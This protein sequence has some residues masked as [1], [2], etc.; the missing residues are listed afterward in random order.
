MIPNEN[1]EVDLFLPKLSTAIE[2]DGPAHFL[3]IWGEKNLQR[4][5]RSDAHKSG[6]L[7][8]AGFVIIRVKHVT[9]NVSGK[10]KRDLLSLV[11]K[12]L[13]EIEKKFPPVG[14]RFVELEI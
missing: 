14:K 5:I 9:K 4:H 12:K 11:T 8:R 3:P 2:I 13:S 7:L 10:L 6:L 1:L